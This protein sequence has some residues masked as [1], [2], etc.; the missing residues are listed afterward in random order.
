MNTELPV[1]AAQQR[2]HE[3]I[4]AHAPLRQ[5][6]CEKHRTLHEWHSA[7]FNNH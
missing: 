1:L 4:A 7:L 6:L 3:K 2:I 5:I